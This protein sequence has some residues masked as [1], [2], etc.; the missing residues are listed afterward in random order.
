MLFYLD[1]CKQLRHEPQWIKEWKTTI[2]LLFFIFRTFC[3]FCNF[4][5]IIIIWLTAT[6][7]AKVQTNQLYHVRFKKIHIPPRDSFWFC[8]RTRVRSVKWWCW[9]IDSLL[10]YSST[11]GRYLHWRFTSRYVQY[12]NK[13]KQIYQISTSYWLQ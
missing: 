3:H 4:W 10:W 7:F 9:A 6:R 11:F 2:W 12:W 8:K 1:R 5:F 13:K